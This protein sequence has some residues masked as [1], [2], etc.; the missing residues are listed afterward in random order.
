M[1]KGKYAEWLEPDGLLRIEGWARDGLT[2]EQIA[3]NMGISKDTFYK[4]KARFADFADALKKNKE[5]VDR[6]VENALHKR[7]IG[8]KVQVNKPLKVKR[9]YFDEYGRKCSVEEVVQAEETVYI[10]P[11]T[12]AQ[13]FWLK[14]RKRDVWGDKAQQVDEVK[15]DDGFIDALNGTA[16]Q[17]W[18]DE[19]GKESDIQI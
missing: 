12:T 2:D 15:Q 16:E 4:W 1:A 11:D 6:E 5:V 8:F 9:E 18:A 13:I 3:H 17:D 10:P 19:T 7:A 14:N